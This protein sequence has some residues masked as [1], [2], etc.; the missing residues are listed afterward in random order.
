MWRV[1]IRQDIIR[2]A[3]LK[4]QDSESVNLMGLRCSSFWAIITSDLTGFEAKFI[5]ND[6][7][8]HR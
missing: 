6:I 7:T 8:I 3:T 2:K 5:R 4:I 1:L